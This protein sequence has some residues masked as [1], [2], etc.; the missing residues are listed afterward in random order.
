MDTPVEAGA[1]PKARG[2]SFVKGNP[3]RPRGA[4]NKTSIALEQLLDGQAEAIVTK[5]IEMA[6]AGDRMALRLVFERVMGAPRERPVPDLKLPPIRTV[7]DC[8]EVSARILA[9]TG[10]GKITPADG[11]ALMHMV[12]TAL[13]A[14]ETGDIEFRIS[15]L[16][17]RNREGTTK[18]APTTN[19]SLKERLALL[20]Q[21]ARAQE[22]MRQIVE[23]MS[24][25]DMRL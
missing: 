4:R 3:G 23:N 12:R 16:E 25:T 9:A 18:R 10:D 14:I 24:E 20:E 22:T 6:L 1:K 15:D 5:V 13:Q 21:E 7:D 19:G 8:A 11:T 17:E 2:K